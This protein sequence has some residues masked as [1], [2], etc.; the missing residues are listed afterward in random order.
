VKIRKTSIW[1]TSEIILWS[2]V[3]SGYWEHFSKET[4]AGM[5]RTAWTGKPF[6]KQIVL[7]LPISDLQIEKP[8]SFLT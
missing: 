3:K 5:C 7:L 2:I 1:K 6:S 8:K 4:S